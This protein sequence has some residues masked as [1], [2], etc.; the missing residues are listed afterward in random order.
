MGSAYERGDLSLVYPISR[1]SGPL[2][3]PLL[4]VLFLREKIYPLGAIGIGLIVFGIYVIHLKSFAC[5]A[6]L[7]PF[8]EMK[9]SASILSLLTGLTIAAYSLVDKVGVS[10]VEPPLY[11]YCMLLIAVVLLSPFVL[12]KKREALRR[13]WRYNRNNIL[14]VGIVVLLTYMMVLFAFRISKV[15]YVVAVREVSIVL[16]AMYGLIWLKEKHV[17][18]KLTGS[19]IIALGVILIGVSR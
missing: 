4:A 8:R 12:V 7:A 15:S 16:S 17:R 18:Q 3:V 1:G 5:D 2:L 19:L 13:E 14:V 6:F 10:F 11:I 9:G